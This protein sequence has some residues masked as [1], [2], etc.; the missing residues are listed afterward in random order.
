MQLNKGQEIYFSSTGSARKSGIVTV[1]KVGRKYAYLENSRYQIDIET[2]RVF[3]KD[4]GTVGQAYLSKED[5]DKER[6]PIVKW[7]SIRE[8][9]SSYGYRT[10]QISD[11]DMD[12][13][14][15]ILGI[16]K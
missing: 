13:I 8:A 12:K 7:Q 5:Y 16:N 10:P 2:A 14:I 3:V 6:E 9:I 15:D 4:Y 11:S 1:G